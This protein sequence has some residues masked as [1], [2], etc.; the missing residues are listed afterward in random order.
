M[1]HRSVKEAAAK[2]PA[3]TMINSRWIKVNPRLKLVVSLDGGAIAGVLVRSI[4]AVAM[5]KTGARIQSDEKETK[6]T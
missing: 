1:R 5:M 4:S 2:V 3:Y 6:Q